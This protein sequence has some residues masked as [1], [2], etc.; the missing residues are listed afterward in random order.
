MTTKQTPPDVLQ[1]LGP[2]RRYALTLTRDRDDAEDLVHD[3]LV[4]AIERQHQFR[5]GL[6][7]RP[8][9]LS[10]LHN[11]F[12]DRIRARR[13]EARRNAE[14]GLATGREAAPSQD[15]ALRLAD[16]RRAFLT[17]PEEQ[18]AALHL[19]SIEGL[20]YEDAA[21]TLGI[22]VGTLVSRVS[23]ARARLREMENGTAGRGEDARDDDASR[24]HRGNDHRGNV[25][26]FRT[27]GGADGR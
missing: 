8:W 15:H 24:D 2:L 12:I 21:A 16:I 20:S 19:V 9:L 7:L 6:A 5:P 18:R 3:T 17:L 23:R 26:P 1:Q 11:S 27:A 10:I 22:P 25:V 4:R 14:I 13:A